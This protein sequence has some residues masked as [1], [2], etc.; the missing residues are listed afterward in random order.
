MKLHGGKMKVFAVG[1]SCTWFKRNNTSFI[2]DDKILIDTPAGSYKDIIKKI[3]IFKLDGIL[4][5]HFHADHFGDFPVFATR[6][7]REGVKNGR[8]SKMKMY[9]PKGML[10]KLVAVNTL[11]GGG[12]DECDPVQLQERIDFIEISGGSEFELSGYKVK[13]FD[14]DHGRTSGLGFIFQDKNGKVVGFSGDTKECD[15]L[16]EILKQS[17]VAF[18]D[19]AAI[20]PAKAHLHADRFMEL[21]KEYSHCKMYPVHT[22]DECQEFAVKNGLNVLNDSDEIIIN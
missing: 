4:I 17:D 1:T 2:L 22:S 15:G 10:E 6:F 3:N 21:E 8:I 7:M 14:V 11:L 9:G 19:M 12:D 5:S 13:I 16:H 20:S 18:V